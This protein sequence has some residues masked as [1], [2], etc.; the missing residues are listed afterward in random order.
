MANKPDVI[1]ISDKCAVAIRYTMRNGK[2]DILEDTM[3]SDPVNYLHGSS[4][5][6]PLLQAQ[7]EGLSAGNKKT[8]CL[9][10][11]SGLVSDNFVFDVIVD[12]VRAALPG[13]IVLGYPVKLTVEKCEADCECYDHN[14][15]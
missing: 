6:H 4:G 13:E 14:N 15:I 12:D 7:L 9:P 2:G 11:E 10:T 8:V 3:N 1:P 5:I